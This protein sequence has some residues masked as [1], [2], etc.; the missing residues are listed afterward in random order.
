MKNVIRS[1][2]NACSPVVAALRRIG[3]RPRIPACRS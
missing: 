3:R 2:E 1:H